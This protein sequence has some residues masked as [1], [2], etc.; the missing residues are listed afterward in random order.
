ML[1]IVTIAGK[2]Y[3]IDVGFGSS[4]PTY[5]LP[6]VEN[7]ISINV[8]TQEMRLMYDTIPDFTRPG[9][10]LWLYQYRHE[11][12]QPWLPAYA[13]SEIEFTPSDFTMMNYFMSTHYTSWFTYLIVCVKMV[14]EDGQIVGDITLTGNEV[15]K[16]IKGESVVLAFCISEEERLKA[17]DEFFGIRL[18]SSERDGIRGMITEIL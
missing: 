15:K 1:N 10:N 8:G 4:G 17:L 16:R 7:E 5:P 12:N 3:V 14:L 13:F 9:Q 2:R 18:S 11:A 6:L